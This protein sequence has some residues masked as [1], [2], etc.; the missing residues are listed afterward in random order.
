MWIGQMPPLSGIRPDPP[1][2][3]GDTN[4]RLLES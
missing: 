1:T 2:F 3:V 4:Y